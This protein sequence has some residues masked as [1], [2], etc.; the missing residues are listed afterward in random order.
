[1]N[2]NCNCKKNNCIL[3]N[4]TS[5]DN[6]L[7][8]AE[9]SNSMQCCDILDHTSDRG[10]TIIKLNIEG[11]LNKSGIKQLYSINKCKLI[12]LVIKLQNNINILSDID[13]RNEETAKELKK[14]YSEILEMND[15]LKSL[16]VKSIKD[17]AENAENEEANEYKIKL[18]QIENRSQRKEIK[19]L[20]KHL[21]KLTNE[22]NKHQISSDDEEPQETEQEQ[23][24]NDDIINKLDEYEYITQFER[25]KK[26]FDVNNFYDVSKFLEIK[27]DI[28]I[29]LYYRAK[30]Q[31]NI[32][33]H[34]E[35]DEIFDVVE[36]YDILNKLN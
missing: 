20:K 5:Y 11:Q 23:E 12:K 25:V 14:G 16:Y 13:K 28:I 31:R 26:Y 10:T 32:K 19:Y 34:P 17:N 1:M 29:N 3:K 15:K 27:T 2:N 36:V 9:L 35:T 7:L 6:F 22:I 8:E 4:I 24:I 21:E 33:A 30:K 18:L